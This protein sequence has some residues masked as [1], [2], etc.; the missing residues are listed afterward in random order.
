M[1]TLTF[2]ANAQSFVI[3]MWHG[4]TAREQDHPDPPCCTCCTLQQSHHTDPPCCTLQQNRIIRTNPAAHAAHCNSG[5]ISALSPHMRGACFIH[6]AFPGGNFIE[7]EHVHPDGCPPL[8]AGSRPRDQLLNTQSPATQAKRKAV[9]QGYRN[10][11]KLN[12]HTHTHTHTG[13]KN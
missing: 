13:T 12:T 3:R 8:S 2:H 6:R 10:L 9:S 11:R 7:Y 4:Y 1:R 5:S